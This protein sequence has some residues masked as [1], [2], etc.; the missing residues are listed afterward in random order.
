[1]RRRRIDLWRAGVQARRAE[2]ARHTA[3]TG[4]FAGGYAA[5][6]APFELPAVRTLHRYVSLHSGNAQDNCGS[7]TEIARWTE[8]AK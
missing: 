3:E 8:G 7:D 2:S 5:R 6:S 1:M 4:A